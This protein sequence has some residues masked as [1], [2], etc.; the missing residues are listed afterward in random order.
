MKYLA[1]DYGTKRIGLALSDDSGTLA[2]PYSIIATGK[3]NIDEMQKII[4][5]EKID[6][7][8]MGSSLTGQGIENP[9]MVYIKNF[10]KALRARITQ[11]IHLVNEFGTTAA[12]RSAHAFTDAKPRRQASPSRTSKKHIDDQAAAMILQRYLDGNKMSHS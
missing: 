5:K 7:V 2:F 8:I 9:V 3:Q 1:I 4:E 12:V 10:E 6:E 11:P